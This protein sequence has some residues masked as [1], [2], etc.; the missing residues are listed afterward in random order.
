MAIVESTGY[1]NCVTIE[2]IDYL[3]SNK[4]LPLF[5]KEL[6]HAFVEYCELLKQ[7]NLLEIKDAET[8]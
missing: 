1:E 5:L 2:K 3:S 7:S 4:V 6:R 8:S